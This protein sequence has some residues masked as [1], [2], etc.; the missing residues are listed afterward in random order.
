MV[1]PFLYKQLLWEAGERTYLTFGASL[2]R[3]HAAGFD[4]H[5]HPSEFFTTTGNCASLIPEL[6]KHL[7]I[8]LDGN[9]IDDVVLTDAV[10]ELTP[11]VLTVGR[12]RLR[13]YSK[14]SNIHWDGNS[15]K[16]NSLQSEESKDFE[17]TPNPQEPRFIDF[18]LVPDLV[19]HLVGREIHYIRSISGRP[20][21]ISCFRLLPLSTLS[22]ITIG[23]F[24][25]INFEEPLGYSYGVR[26]RS[27]K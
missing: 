19:T 17:F 21:N 18:S 4:R 13:I 6:D 23:G 26:E 27:K 22:P 9:H 24:D 11:S 25:V 12:M 15:Y 10:A 20:E 16:L 5:P 14:V 3:I 1:D 2:S 8:G 7:G